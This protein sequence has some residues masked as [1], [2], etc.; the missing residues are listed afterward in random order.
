[1]SHGKMD[2]TRDL[3]FHSTWWWQNRRNERWGTT[4]ADEERGERVR[5]QH[6]EDSEGWRTVL[7]RERKTRQ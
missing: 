3:G 6:Q 2:Q 4:W 5:W 7:S 1:M